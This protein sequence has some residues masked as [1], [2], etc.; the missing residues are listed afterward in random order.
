VKQ[1][2]RIALIALAIGFAIAFPLRLEDYVLSL[3]LTLMLYAP[4]IV[5][6]LIAVRY[7]R[8]TLGAASLLALGIVV[9]L[10]LFALPLMNWLAFQTRLDL[11]TPVILSLPAAAVFFIRPVAGVRPATI[12][13]G[14]AQAWWFVHTF[15]DF[16]YYRGDVVQ[17]TL[18]IGSAMFLVAAITPATTQTRVAWSTIEPVCVVLIGWLS[19]LPFYKIHTQNMRIPDL[20]MQM[21][22][23]ALPAAILGL[24]WGLAAER[25][26]RAK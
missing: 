14:V 25:R 15:T 3:G 20:K 23:V 12:V 2:L 21:F 10:R 9:C 19:S 16:I 17:M 7:R 26:V 1:R 4:A 24:I 5:V 13:A 22:S 11:W 6:A 8:T 18:A